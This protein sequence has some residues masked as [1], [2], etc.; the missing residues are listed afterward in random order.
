M[1]CEGVTG[2]LSTSLMRCVESI[3]VLLVHT[4]QIWE[5]ECERERKGGRKRGGGS[6]RVADDSKC[7]GGFA[8]VTQRRSCGM[9][10]DRRPPADEAGKC[11]IVFNGSS[12]GLRSELLRGNWA[13]QI[14]RLS[15]R[16]MKCKYAASSVQVMTISSV[17]GMTRNEFRR[18][19]LLR[20]T[21]WKLFSE[22]RA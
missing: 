13:L 1:H 7:T 10:V 22:H 14:I 9:Q 3:K 6:E 21:R 16:W 12:F 20:L 15:G 2:F 11:S 5:S 18:H 8:H 19:P 17:S 4:P